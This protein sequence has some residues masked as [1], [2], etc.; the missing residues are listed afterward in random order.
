MILLRR[1]SYVLLSNPNGCTLGSKRADIKII[2]NDASE[3]LDSWQYRVSVDLPYTGYET[4]YE[5]PALIRLSTS[6]TGFVYSSFATNSG[7][8]LRFATGD[9]KGE[10][11]CIYSIDCWDTNGESTVWVQIPVM[12]AGGTNLW[13]YWGNPDEIEAP[14]YTG[15]GSIWDSSYQG[16]WHLQSNVL[17]STANG[18]DGTLSGGGRRWP[19]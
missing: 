15:D 5:W 9:E 2:D 3:H 16:V 8:D 12:P 10:I 13:I 19:A 17:D 14:I 6:I 1:C 18:Y 11:P 4:L 7:G